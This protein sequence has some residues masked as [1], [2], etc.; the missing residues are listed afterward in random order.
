MALAVQFDLDR[1]GKAAGAAG[2]GALGKLR[3]AQAT[4]GRQQRQRF[5]EIGLAGAVL[6]A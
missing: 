3:P 4:A 5:E 2:P 1:Q 6:A